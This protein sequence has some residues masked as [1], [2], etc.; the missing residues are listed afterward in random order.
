[1]N[2]VIVINKEK[3]ITS[4]DVVNRLN[5]ILKTK[6]IGHTGTLDPMASGVL[7]C[8]IGKY[9]KLASLIT[10]EEKEYI[11]EIKLGI[12]T[13]TLDI[14]GNI[15]KEESPTKLDIKQ[16][17]NVL[18]S[19][20][21]YYKQE[22]PLYSATHVNGKRLYEYAREGKEVVLPIKDVYIKDIAL[23]NYENDKIK[24]K[25]LVSK[26][27]YIRSLIQSICQKLN[28]LGT[29]SS[30]ERIKQGK[31][32]ISDAYFL[33]DIEKNNFHLFTIPEL[34]DVEKIELTKE[35]ENLVL[36]GNKIK[37]AKEGYILF[38][39]DKIEKALYYCENGIGKLIILF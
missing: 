21:G 7:V 22:V 9:T 38:V 3:G 20:K 15:L 33:E 34:L 27:T 28:V 13:D 2:G 37:I 29:M 25:A 35:L 1:M 11:A 30:L 8:L 16:I 17:E 31:F 26:G 39:K 24:F 23:I 32:N 10:N 19:F 14:T 4:R 18:N 12:E 6:K 5:K 36:N